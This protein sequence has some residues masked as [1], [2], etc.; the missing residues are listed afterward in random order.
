MLFYIKLYFLTLLIFLGID[1]VWLT[2]VA[3]NFYK[4]HIGHLM[5][6]NPNLVVAGIFYA[7]FVVGIIVFSVIPALN[8]GSW[9]T[10][11]LLGALYG[12]MTYGTYD[13]TNMATL[14][15]WPTIVTVVDI[16][17]G[18]LLNASTATLVLLVAQKFLK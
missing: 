8:S 10:A 11:F 13:F 7:T 14:K 12:F 16:L 5:A 18:T 17:W 15:E 6:Q 1:F 4:K 3:P 9:K 2:Q